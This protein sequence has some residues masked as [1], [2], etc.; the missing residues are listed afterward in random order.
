MKD[1]MLSTGIFKHTSI[2]SGAL[3]MLLGCSDLGD[4]LVLQPSLDLDLTALDFGQVTVGHGQSR[5]LNLVNAGEGD[6]NADLILVQDSTA[7]SLDTGASIIVAPGDT[8]QI[9]I[10]FGPRAA[11]I[12][13]GN[14]IITS[15]DPGQP[16]L[17]IPL[18]GTGSA[19]LVPGISVSRNSIDFGSVLTASTSNMEFTISSSGTDTLTIDSVSFSDQ[20]YSIDV[21][22][23]FDLAPGA[24]AAIDLQFQ[25]VN[26]GNYDATLSIHS[27]VDSSPTIITITA[28]ATAPVSYSASIQP[29]WDS[30][31]SGCHGSSGGLNL[32]SYA[33]L[34]S[35]GNNGAVVVAGDGANSRIVQRLRG[36]GGSRM[37]L[38]GAALPDATIEMVE[39]WINQGALDN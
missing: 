24:T 14:L 27:N 32:S 11:A 18:S 13:A 7:F 31:C 34:M 19:Q 3:I 29:I 28:D 17:S 37:P 5:S 1:S 22:T 10:N 20:A 26:A 12:Y 21:S 9:Q 33:Q 4:P 23:P 6:L 38:N 36:I 30:N 2:I 15:N 16:E 35:G 39:T 8:S 25:P